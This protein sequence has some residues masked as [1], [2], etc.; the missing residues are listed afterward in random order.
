[1][2]IMKVHFTSCDWM[3]LAQQTSA[4]SECCVYRP[5]GNTFKWETNYSSYTKTTNKSKLK[6]KSKKT[7]LTTVCMSERC[8]N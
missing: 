8:A 4:V 1:M 6:F 5:V 2:E 7:L 3:I